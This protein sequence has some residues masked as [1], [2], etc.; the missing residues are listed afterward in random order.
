[1]DLG[2]RVTVGNTFWRQW[3]CWFEGV[4]LPLRSVAD[5]ISVAS[6]YKRT[7]WF[8][9]FKSISD[10]QQC[11]NQKTP[12][13][14]KC[15]PS[16]PLPSSS[17][18]IAL[19]TGNRGTGKYIYSPR[20]CCSFCIIATALGYALSELVA[21]RGF[22]LNRGTYGILK[23]AFSSPGSLYRTVT[24]VAS[25]KEVERQVSHEWSGPKLFDDWSLAFEF[26]LLV[27]PGMI[28]SCFK[29]FP[30]T[31]RHS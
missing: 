29:S 10:I 14:P 26:C 4:S 20:Y 5:A 19:I 28:Y 27:E 8:I 16:G 23:T 30:H 11:E 25:Y 3:R 18:S 24:S 31:K 17:S 2:Q 7:S 6:Y 9:R 1:M 21:G 13:R 22:I 15:L 12:P